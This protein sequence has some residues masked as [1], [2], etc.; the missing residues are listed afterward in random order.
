MLPRADGK[1]KFGRRSGI[2]LRPRKLRLV[3]SVKAR[4]KGAA[5]ERCPYPKIGRNCVR[6]GLRADRIRLGV[7]A[8]GPKQRFVKAETVLQAQPS[9]AQLVI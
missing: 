5:G 4:S 8:R 9:P 7:L 1:I 6:T 3:S 2:E